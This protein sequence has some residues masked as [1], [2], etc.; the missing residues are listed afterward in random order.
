MARDVGEPPTTAQDLLWQE[1]RRRLLGVWHC[2]IDL[3]EW[4]GGGRSG[5]PIAVVARLGRGF[6][7][8]VA[9]KFAHADEIANWDTALRDCPSEFR[10]KHLIKIGTTF[11]PESGDSGYWLVSLTIA[12]GDL[13]LIRPASEMQ[14]LRGR[15]FSVACGA[16]VRSIISEWNPD[17]L[18][19]PLSRISPGDYLDSIF[20]V[21]RVVPGNRLLTWL[22]SVGIDPN[23]RLIRRPGWGESLPNPLTLASAMNSDLRDTS[24]DLR[25]LYGRAHGDLHLR[26]I[27]LQIT[28]PK[29]QE[30]RLIDLGGY[31][32][33]S[34]LAR[35][36]MH[37]LLS[38]ALEWL[39]GGIVPGMPVSRELVKVIIQPRQ[40]SPEKEYQVVSSAI[41]SAGHAWA[42][43]KNLGDEWTRQSLLAIVGNALRYASR[44]LVTEHDMSATRGWFF[45]IA[46]A[47][48]HA[49]LEDV[50]LWHQYLHSYPSPPERPPRFPA[51]S[52][53]E[54]RAESGG[55]TEALILPFRS[56]PE[57]GAS[58]FETGSVE[59]RAYGEWQRLVDALQ[60]TTFDPDNWRVLA[61]RTDDLLCRL[62]EI[63][64]PH[65]MADEDIARNI[66]L[67]DQ[68]LSRVLRPS[69]SRTELQSACRRADMLRTWLLDL[70]ADSD[71]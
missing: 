48:A 41:H 43:A 34:P 25:V 59:I 18:E 42:S 30:Y 56:S 28:P 24:R 23:D 20:N 71:S 46:A 35:D 62:R 37:L 58:T 54:P 6:N 16:I 32:S 17:P 29:H 33:K 1:A 12:G 8:K 2:D 51:Q 68:T 52:E 26:N 44:D 13:S 40:P 14:P 9:V 38:I 49:Y 31:D 55:S 57:H 27:L 47:A 70:L 5:A 36:P 63:R 19:H 22:Q 39:N 10:E 65:P 45:D 66:R 3:D 69:A 11:Q 64:P 60:R 67:L 61:V 15:S 21:R 53:D 7:D 50:G 4:L